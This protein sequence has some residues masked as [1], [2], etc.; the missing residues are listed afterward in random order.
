MGSAGLV[1]IGIVVSVFLFL[2]KFKGET[3]TEDEPDDQADNEIP[4]PV[5]KVDSVVPVPAY[6]AT[7]IGGCLFP[8]PAPGS[9]AAIIIGVSGNLANKNFPIEKELFSIGAD[10]GN[11]LCIADDDYLS[12]EHAYLRYQQGLLFVHDSNSRNGTTVNEVE[13][14]DMGRALDIG[15]RIRVGQ[16]AFVIEHAPH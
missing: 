4:P 14:T 12:G 2:T 6:D 11:D 7:R 9:P 1:I 16:S 10:D 13:V 5:N 8:E 3:K 15:D